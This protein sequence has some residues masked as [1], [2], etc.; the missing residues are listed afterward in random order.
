[1]QTNTADWLWP[2]G[3][4][5]I[6]KVWNS[7]PPCVD[8]LSFLGTLKEIFFSFYDLQMENRTF[9]KFPNCEPH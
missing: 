5:Q 8:A 7:L 4:L 3:G 9:R 6:W 2:L 1:M